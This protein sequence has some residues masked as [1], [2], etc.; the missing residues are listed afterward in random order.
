MEKNVKFVNS[1]K[2][3]CLTIGNLPSS[4]V[5]SMSYY[6]TLLWLYN[7]LKEEVIPNINNNTEEIVK[8]KHYF[9]TLDV[10]DE[11]NN[12]LEE[13]SESGE[14]QE[15]IK[16]YLEAKNVVAFTSKG[17]MKESTN[18]VEG[19]IVRTLGNVS[20][21]TGD[22]YYYYVREKGEEETADDNL[23]VQLAKENLIAIR[24]PNYERERITELENQISTVVISGELQ[25]HGYEYSTERGYFEEDYINLPTGYTT[26][27]TIIMTI[28]YSLN[29]DDLGYNDDYFVKCFCNIVNNNM[30]W[31]RFNYTNSVYTNRKG[32][33]KIVI[34]KND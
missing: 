18:L 6:E 21:Y 10:Q 31:L 1:I 4:Y 17:E 2:D 16:I 26:D 30:L 28:N 14:L 11:I 19:S 9:E 23:K 22:G 5:D 8:L 24:V 3:L 27:N 15:I 20:L 29:G 12:K 34:K 33:Y 25:F 7:F 32:I 13:M